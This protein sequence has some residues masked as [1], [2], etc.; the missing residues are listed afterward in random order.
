MFGSLVSSLAYNTLVKVMAILAV[1]AMFV[2]NSFDGVF[3]ND[4]WY[5]AVVAAIVIGPHAL[6]RLAPEG[7]GGTAKAA[8][9]FQVWLPFVAVL[10]ASLRFTF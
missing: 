6:D 9:A 1:L 4:V 5:S 7:G 2:Q 8:R 3:S 10:I